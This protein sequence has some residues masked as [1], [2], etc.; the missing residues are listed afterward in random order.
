MSTTNGRRLICL[1]KIVIYNINVVNPGRESAIN[2]DM[3][4]IHTLFT[5]GDDK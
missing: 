5:L 1:D 3:I 4:N 2:T